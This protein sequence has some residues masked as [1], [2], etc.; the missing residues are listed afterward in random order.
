MPNEGSAGSLA[1]VLEGVEEVLGDVLGDANVS[2]VRTIMIT[3]GV[4]MIDRGL[5]GVYI[6]KVCG[7]VC[8]S[9]HLISQ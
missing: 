8:M 6:H 9:G 2:I 1:G 7:Q 4:G 5:G 3:A